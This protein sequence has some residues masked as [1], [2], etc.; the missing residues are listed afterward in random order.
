LG[1]GKR[2]GLVGWFDLMWMMYGGCGGDL[3]NVGVEIGV[4]R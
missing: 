2:K 3:S 1:G 4:K